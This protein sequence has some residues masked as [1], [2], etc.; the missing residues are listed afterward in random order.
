MMANVRTYHD[1]EPVTGVLLTAPNAIAVCKVQ[2]RNLVV[3]RHTSKIEPLNDEARAM[4]R[5]GD[6]YARRDVPEAIQKI[7]ANPDLPT[8]ALDG[9]TLEQLE[10]L[11]LFLVDQYQEMQR[12]LGSTSNITRR[13]QLIPKWERCSAVLRHVN[14]RL[15]DAR[16]AVEVAKS[17]LAPNQERDPNALLARAAEI[18]WQQ[19]K[20]GNLTPEHKAFIHVIQDYIVNLSKVAK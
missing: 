18:L 4:L 13:S 2:I 6:A 3:V 7:A 19:H 12:A 1:D 5:S 15:K 11:R 8:A 9:W 10:A 14:K 20:A 17:G 16:R